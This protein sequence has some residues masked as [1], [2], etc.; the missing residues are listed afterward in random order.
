[1]NPAAVDHTAHTHCVLDL[2]TLA[3]CPRAMVI[4]IAVVFFTPGKQKGWRESMEIAPFA[5]GDQGD[6]VMDHDTLIWWAQRGKDGH[7]IPGMRSTNTLGDMVDWFLA[8]WHAHAAPDCEIWSQGLAFDV[9]ILTDI[10]AS[11]GHAPPWAY[12]NERCLRTLKKSLGWKKPEGRETAHRA[13]ADAMEEA[14]DLEE[15][16]THLRS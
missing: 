4:E 8:R 9:A 5:G 7:P 15:I 1:V 2:E 12:W 10:L 11:Y 6:R 13:L 3:V 16:L 14:L